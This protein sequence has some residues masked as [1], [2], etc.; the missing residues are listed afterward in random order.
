MVLLPLFPR[1]KLSNAFRKEAPKLMP[2]YKLTYTASSKTE[3]QT[4]YSSPVCYA[5]VPGLREGFES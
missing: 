3:K 4:D 1:V 2:T 5:H